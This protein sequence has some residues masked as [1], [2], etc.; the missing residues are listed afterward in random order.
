M[1]LEDHRG[2]KPSDI[3]FRDY[4]TTAVYEDIDSLASHLQVPPSWPHQ[5]R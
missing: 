5:R 3:R 1:S 2:G 4:Y